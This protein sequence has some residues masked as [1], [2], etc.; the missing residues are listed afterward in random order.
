MY[1]ICPNKY[2]TYIYDVGTD[3]SFMIINQNGHWG[4]K[5][6]TSAKKFIYVVQNMNMKNF[7]WQ[8]LTLLGSK[9]IVLRL[10]QP[11]N[12]EGLKS[13]SEKNKN[14]NLILSYVRELGKCS[15]V[16]KLYFLLILK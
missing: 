2:Q 5:A 15:L 9:V 7:F 12:E 4:S 3:M 16:V 6:L 10:I 14:I 11:L 13:F 1:N 8:H